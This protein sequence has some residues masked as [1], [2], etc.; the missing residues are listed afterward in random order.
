MINITDSS[1]CCGCSACV[2]TCPVKCIVMHRDGEGFDYPA[3]DA[4]LCISCGKCDEVCPMISPVASSPINAYALRIPEYESESSS[5]GVFPALASQV[6]D[7]GG[8]VAGAAFDSKLHLSHIIVNDKAGLAKLRGSK[9]VQSEIGETYAQTRDLL[10]LGIEVL[11]SGT[12]CQ[13]AG[14][15]KYLHKPYDNLL[16]VDV[17]CHGV[18][19]PG[20]WEKYV[21]DLGVNGVRFRDKCDSWKRYKVAYSYS[22]R[23]KKISVSS[24]PYM[25]SYL[26]NMNVRPSCYDCKFRAGYHC[27]DITLGDFWN[28]SNVCPKMD[29]GKGVSAVLVNSAKGQQAIE[30]LKQSFEGVNIQNIKYDEATSHN[31]GF[32]KKIDVPASREEFFAGFAQSKDIRAYIKKYVELKSCLRDLYDRFHTYMSLIKRRVL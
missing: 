11:F 32:V 23:V 13:I 27:S 2:N 16:T 4:S 30:S 28:V 18:P 3:A 29:D 17:A 31:G 12:T 26:R 10:D 6:L 14:L 24:D 22:G 25:M 19:S 15:L 7:Q 9:Y 20:V 1:K 5:G 21:Q 8:V